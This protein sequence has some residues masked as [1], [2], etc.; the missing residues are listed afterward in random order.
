MRRSSAVLCGLAV[1]ALMTLALTT[2]AR[3]GMA[4]AVGIEETDPF[5]QIY[6]LEQI[7]VLDGAWGL[8]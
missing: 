8:W 3:S 2:L 5:E 1:L 4:L 6:G 7:C